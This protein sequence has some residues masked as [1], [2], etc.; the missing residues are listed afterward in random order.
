MVLSVCWQWA[1]VHTAYQGNWTGLFCAGDRFTRPAEIQSY[2]HVF[3]GS[4][5]YDGQFYQLIAHDPLLRHGY[6]RFI[7]APRLRYRRIL[8]PSLAYL[9]AAGQPDFIDAAFIAICWFFVGLGTFSLAR[10]AADAGR[11]EWWG[12]LFFITPAT[13]LGLDRET[14]D[15]SLAALAVASLLAARKQRWV[16]LWFAL[17]GAVLSKE[18]GALMIAGVVVWLGVQKKFRLAAVFSSSVLPA[19]AWFVFVQ[20]H[21]HGDYSTSGFGLI[22]PFF[23]LLT[24]PLDPGVPSLIF[25]I[26]ALAAVGGMLWA[27]VRSVV[28]AVQDRLVNLEILFS[29]LFGA[30]VLLFETAAIWGDPDGFPRIYSPL[31]VCLI[32]ATW[33]KGFGQT[34][35]SFGLVA[36]P[37]CMQWGWDLARPVLG[38]WLGR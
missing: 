27:A 35:T 16:L 37:I 17:A 34:L 6:D 12:L 23:V 32:A 9:F 28:L 30:L 19:I 10:L 22:T 15:I 1:E 13:L 20:S 24:I 36:W 7:D 31:L 18:T 2:E 5:G 4:W 25:R 38:T 29:F 33:R 3:R 11:S 8:M 21:T 26:A 14:V